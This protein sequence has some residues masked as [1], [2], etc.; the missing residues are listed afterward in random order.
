MKQEYTNFDIELKNEDRKNTIFNKITKVLNS[1]TPIQVEDEILQNLY[2]SFPLKNVLN[3]KNIYQK[4]M[5]KYK[6]YVEKNITSKDIIDFF[7]DKSIYAQLELLLP[8]TV[9]LSENQKNIKFTIENKPLDNDSDDVTAHDWDCLMYESTHGYYQEI[10][11]EEPIDEIKKLCIYEHIHI[12]FGMIKN[13]LIDDFKNY[14]Y[15]GTSERLN[16]T[17]EKNALLNTLKKIENTLGIDSK[18][19]S[20]LFVTK[21]K[22]EKEGRNQQLEQ[23]LKLLR[24]A[25][26]DYVL[27][28]D[29]DNYFYPFVANLFY[30]V[31]QSDKVVLEHLDLIRAIKE[32]KYQMKKLGIENTQQEDEFVSKI[33]D[34]YEEVQRSQIWNYVITLY[35]KEYNSSYKSMK[36]LF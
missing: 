9:S 13:C 19:Y 14:K 18:E 7:K 36:D 26:V 31:Y 10:E 16:E 15:T 8:Y 5:E 24:N 27:K 4:F 17:Q 11:V 6:V 22:M 12:Y 1:E 21:I 3:Q 33:M 25:N 34:F 29:E 32:R 30:V 28:D 35:A 20:P 23:L 2:E